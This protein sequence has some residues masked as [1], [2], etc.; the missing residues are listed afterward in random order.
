MALYLYKF[1]NY[2]NR[3]VKR[4]E[5][6]EDYGDPIS[7]VSNTNFNP[8]DEISTTHIV[9]FDGSE[10]DYAIN[11]DGEVIISRWYIIEKVRL[12]AEQY[13]LTLYRD[14]LADYLSDI[15]NSPIYLEKGWVKSIN[16]PAIYNLENFTA[17]QI[18]KS[19]TLLKDSTGCAWIVGYYDKKVEKDDVTGTVN[20]DIDEFP[21][22]NLT[23]G[24]NS[25]TYYKYVTGEYAFPL[26]PEE[27]GVI[28]CY[29]GSEPDVSGNYPSSGKV[30]GG[31]FDY[32][33]SGEVNLTRDYAYNARN[34]KLT[35][36]ASHVSIYE[37]E[38]AFKKSMDDVRTAVSWMS[39]L[40]NYLSTGDATMPE[41]FLAENGKIIK[42]IDGEYYRVNTVLSGTKIYSS[43]VSAGGLFNNVKTACQNAQVYVQ[44][45]GI[46]LIRDMF[47][48]D[49]DIDSVEVFTTTITWKIK[50]TRI[51]S[52]EAT[53]NLL[54]TD[55]TDGGGIIETQGVPYN[56]FAIPFGEVE[57]RQTFTEGNISVKIGDSE[58]ALAI[59]AG[60]QRK[61]GNFLYDIQLV[62]YFPVPQ[63][64]H[65][66]GIIKGENTKQISWVKN[67]SDTFYYPIVNVPSASFVVNEIRSPI[68]KGGSVTTRKINNQ[69]DKYRLCSPNYSNYF[70]FSAE[71]NDGVDYFTVD[72]EYKPW[73]PYIHINPNFKGLYGQDFNDPRGLI[74]GGDF[75]LTQV[76][77][78]WQTYQINNKNYQNIFDR[79]IQNMEVQHKYAR[80]QDIGNAAV[81]TLASALSGGMTGSII[82][83][84]IGGFVGA[85]VSMLASGA[86][87]A[88]D[89][90]INQKLRDEAKD[91]TIDLYNM[92]LQNIQAL[93]TTIG[94]VSAFNPNNKIFPVL[95][96]YTC[97]DAEREAFI[98]KIL[99]NGMT[100][101]RIGTLNDFITGTTH[102]YKGQLI[103]IELHDDFHLINTIA[104]ELNKGVFI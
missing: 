42:T 18:K 17:N 50:L 68:P 16:D 27:S 62:P 41:T 101:D 98:K 21:H 69:C 84:P 56:I 75:S 32:D 45:G 89:V 12:R 19:E 70:D 97:T 83:G 4:F 81:G 8:N 36:N 29:F 87:G 51:Y 73:S 85:G 22:E 6:L 28:R 44:S 25:Y 5:N 14:A 1:N 78:Q 66:L 9:N 39:Q 103:R 63:M 99:Y 47:A 65:A 38:N 64:I 24:L 23:G 40:S 33:S 11:A 82:A 88:L 2:Y 80:Q 74:L 54:N 60:I 57:T 7:I 34:P 49:A 90:S 59:A 61:L 46:G 52:L 53:F 35:Q 3:I 48:T 37:L 95:E 30:Y 93:P 72:C 20:V 76:V 26:K 94:K 91:Y 13:R 92:Q 100:I 15:L 86:A 71:A 10:C 58:T 31:F 104:H 67:A 79:Q 43:K 55:G 96:Y 102:Y 77:D